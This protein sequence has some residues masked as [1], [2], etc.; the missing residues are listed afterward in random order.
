MA[1]INTRIH[2]IYSV[3]DV[4]Q[5]VVD[6]LRKRG[7]NVDLKDVHEPGADVPMPADAF[8]VGFQGLVVDVEKPLPPA[9][10]SR[11]PG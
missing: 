10:N 6:D 5:L 3:N 8:I 4:K 11:G 2:A 9:Y 7:V 1:Q